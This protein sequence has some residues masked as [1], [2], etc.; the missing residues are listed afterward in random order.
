VVRDLVTLT[1]DLQTGLQ[2]TRAAFVSTSGFLGLTVFELET[3]MQQTDGR[4][5]M[6]NAVY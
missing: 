1:S 5:A 2:V 6:R 3:D 4:S